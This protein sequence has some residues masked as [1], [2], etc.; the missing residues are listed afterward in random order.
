MS[1]AT[2]TYFPN[3]PVHPGVSLSDELAFLSLSVTDLATRT[4]VSKKH[5]SHIL[6][7][8]ATITSE[9][10]LKLEKVT[11]TKAS[12]WNN[13][14]RNYQASL[15]MIEE[16]AHVT[17]ESEQIVDF[18]ET[19]LELQK[20]GV[21]ERYTWTRSNFADITRNLLSFFSVHS[22]KY[23][24]NTQPVAFRRR[25]Q[26]IN[27]NTMAAII[28]LGEK[29]AQ[30]V[31]TE[32]FDKKALMGS[33]AEIKS[34]SLLEPNEYMPKLEEKLRTLGVVLVCVPGFKHTGLQGAAKWLDSDKAMIIV[35]SRGQ[36]I[37]TSVTEDLFWFNLFHELGHVILHGKSEE[38]IDLEDK[39][40]SEEEHAANA[41]ANK[42]LMGGFEIS[43]LQEYKS[44]KGGI[45]ADKAIKGLSL[46]FGIAPSIVAGQMSY[47]YQDR[48]D[49]VY[50]VLSGYKRPISYMNIGSLLKN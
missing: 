28:R 26:I 49:N 7:G 43:D 5:L 44:N 18:K 50:A 47:L 4:G 23:I 6:N 20:H 25:E 46:R 48:Q 15:A 41:F 45:N 1:T 21:L 29:K 12:F 42:Q 38:F 2:Q 34:Y 31:Q 14:S 40:D 3:K 10:A 8:K 37:N 30:I 24:P 32:P 22:L 17:L 9:V 11:G 27:Q 35:K 36:E 16:R 19:Y 39:T 13:L 33:L